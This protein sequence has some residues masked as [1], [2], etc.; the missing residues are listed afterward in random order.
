MKQ[1]S[2][3]I[4]L[5]PISLNTS[6]RLVRFGK[7]TVKIKTEA[8]RLFE[9]EF[10]YYLSEYET[11]KLHLLDDYDKRRHSVEVEVYFYLNEKDYFT[12]PKKGFK[13]ISEKSMDLDNMI[14]VA[15]DQVFGWLG[16]D[17]SQMTKI[18]A[19]KIP[20]NDQATMVFRIS[21]IPIPELFVVQASEV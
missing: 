6:H 13:T 16:V 14:K 15:N 4:P 8:T 1:I 5:K 7:R 11:L 2:F 17:D 10:C 12:K 21:L 18:S 19:Q 20:T 3:Q 9:E